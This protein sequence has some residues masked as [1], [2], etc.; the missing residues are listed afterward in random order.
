LKAE[1]F[2]KKDVV[3]FYVSPPSLSGNRPADHEAPV[4]PKDLEDIRGGGRRADD[5]LEA[6]GRQL[7]DVPGWTV[8]LRAGMR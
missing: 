7:S 8:T 1:T 2:P 3:N 4:H 5:D 6:A